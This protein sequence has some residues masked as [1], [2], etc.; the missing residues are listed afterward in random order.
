MKAVI[1][2]HIHREAQVKG[3]QLLGALGVFTA[4]ALVFAGMPRIV[5][6]A[7][8][9]IDPDALDR[10]DNNDSH[11]SGG[12][13]ATSSSAL[14]PTGGGAGTVPATSTGT[15]NTSTTNN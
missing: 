13:G 12:T 8:G 11:E 1:L 6:Y 2:E 14:T 3:Q 15:S 5:V 10:G 7:D 9:P 4:L